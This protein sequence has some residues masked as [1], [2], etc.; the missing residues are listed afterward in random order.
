MNTVTRVLAEPFR[1]P[2]W[3]RTAHALLALPAG[4]LGVPHLLARRTLGLDLGRPPARRLVLYALLA[5][6]PNVV[7]A[8]VTLYGWSLVPMNLGWP[9]R[10]GDPAGAWG[11]P[12]F[13]GAWAFHA[14]LGGVGFLLLMPW[15]VRGVTSLQR[16][17]ALRLL[18]GPG[19]PAGSS[20]APQASPNSMDGTSTGSIGSRVCPTYH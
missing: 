7:A 6:P 20:E 3:R 18:T 11:G 1:A 17:L 5:T 4:A 9:L 13:A 14:L 2:T 15:A 19:S 16:R 8:L 12:S 10:A